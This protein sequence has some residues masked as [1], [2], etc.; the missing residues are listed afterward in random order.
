MSPAVGRIGRVDRRPSTVGARRDTDTLVARQLRLFAVALVLV[1]APT[2]PLQLYAQSPA[3]ST[4]QP[5][6]A[7]DYF[8]QLQS[9]AEAYNDRVGDLYRVQVWNLDLRRARSLL[10]YER[11]NLYVVGAEATAAYSL[12]LDGQLRVRDLSRQVR[13]D[14]SVRV[15]VDRAALQ[16]IRSEYTQTRAVRAAY[17]G[18]DVRVTGVGVGH[19]VQWWLADQ[20]VRSHLESV[21]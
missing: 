7:D 19:W 4:P 5:A 13:P 12:R 6:W 9:A 11:V 21:S 10:R 2:L 3:V 18:G 20:W 8:G 17:L 15:V 1:S 16:R 14:A